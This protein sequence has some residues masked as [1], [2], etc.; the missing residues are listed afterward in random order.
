[1]C[2]LCR[3]P[4]NYLEQLYANRVEYVPE[5]IPNDP[6]YEPLLKQSDEHITRGE[7]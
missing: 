5:E 7:N 1:M 4:G 2:G 3:L 6:A